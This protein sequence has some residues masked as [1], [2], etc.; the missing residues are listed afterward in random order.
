MRRA[1]AF[2]LVAAVA[3]A[4]PAALMAATRPA[5][6]RQSQTGA[7]TGVAKDAQGQ[8]LAGSTVRVRSV[9]TGN[10]AAEVVADAAGGFTAPALAPGSYIVEVV[11][12]AGQVIG[13]SPTVTV[14]AGTTAT[15]TVT[16]TAL[17][18]VAAGAAGGGLSV[19]GLGTGASIAVIGAAATAAVVGVVSAVKTASP[20]GL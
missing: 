13:L 4:A 3:F 16:A 1:I 18:A 19:L 10:V 8:N 15:V 7:L 6:A 17:G 12:A 2:G 5:A 14:V 20:S 9:S 11:N